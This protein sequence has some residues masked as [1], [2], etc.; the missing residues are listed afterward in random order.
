MDAPLTT[1][2]AA[3]LLDVV[4][5]TVRL[6]ERNGLLRAIR[7]E[8]GVRLFRRRDVEALAVRRRRTQRRVSEKRTESASGVKGSSE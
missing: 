2:D 6:W 5:D 8:S 7:T 3:K 1:A 4:P